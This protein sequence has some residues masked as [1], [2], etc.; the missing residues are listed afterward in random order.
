[1]QNENYVQQEH[2]FFNFRSGNFRLDIKK[3]RFLRETG[4]RGHADEMYVQKHTLRAG[5]GADKT[6]DPEVSGDVI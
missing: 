6:I 3:N 2:F 4:N 5:W 1:M